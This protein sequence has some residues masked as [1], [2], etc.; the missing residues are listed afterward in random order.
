MAKRVYTV[1]RASSIRGQIVFD[2]DASVVYINDDD[3]DP[4]GSQATDRAALLALLS[5]IPESDQTDSVTVWNDSGV[6]KV[7]SAP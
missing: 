2:D 4:S 3:V 5:A 6:L 7:S 1:K